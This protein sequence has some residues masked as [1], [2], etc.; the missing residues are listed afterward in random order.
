MKPDEILNKV[1][2]QVGGAL[3]ALGGMQEENGWESIFR[4]KWEGANDMDSG[5]TL[6]TP[7]MNELLKDIREQKELSRTSALRLALEKVEGKKME[8]PGKDW[9]DEIERVAGTRGV[10]QLLGEIKQRNDL[11]DDIYQALTH[12]LT[13]P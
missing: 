13:K 3:R 12:E 6:S 8:R 11:L 5:Q 10:S 4:A 7:F 9:L 1:D 2:Q